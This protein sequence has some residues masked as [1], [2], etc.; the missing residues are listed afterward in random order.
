M[1][2]KLRN[3]MLTSESVIDELKREFRKVDLN[4][5]HQISIAQLGQVLNNMGANLKPSEL[6]SL[7]NDI[8]VDR[9][10]TVDIDELVAFI[11]RNNNNTS[12]IT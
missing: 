10:R 3:E 7:F 6:S 2:E 1:E 9:S 5:S 11:V 8:D 12:A 4:N